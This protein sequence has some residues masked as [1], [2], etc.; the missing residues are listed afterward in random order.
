[1][2]NAEQVDVCDRSHLCPDVFSVSMSVHLQLQCLCSTNGYDIYM[3]F[4]TEFHGNTAGDNRTVSSKQ[5]TE[6]ADSVILIEE[7]DMSN[8]DVIVVRVDSDDD[9]VIVVSDD[10][11]IVDLKDD[12]Q[13]FLSLEDAPLPRHA[14]QIC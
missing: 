6:G 9:D 5:P 13:R 3:L 2:L 12:L 10:S 4:L 7:D 8:G 14:G 11:D 1:M